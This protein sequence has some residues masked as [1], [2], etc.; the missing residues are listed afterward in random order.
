MPTIS[1]VSDSFKTVPTEYPLREAIGHRTA[2]EYR[3]SWRINVTGA[4]GNVK[5]RSSK[6]SGTK[7]SKRSG[8]LETLDIGLGLR[9][10]SVRKSTKRPQSRR[11]LAS[12][13]KTKHLPYLLSFYCRHGADS[14]H[15]WAGPPPFAKRRS[16]I[17]KSAWPRHFSAA[18]NLARLEED[19]RISKA[20]RCVSDASATGQHQVGPDLPRL[21]RDS[22]CPTP[23][24]IRAL[25]MPG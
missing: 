1:S 14:S 18:A 20:K 15:P 9:T 8:H 13:R 7:F 11:S 4:D 19:D 2:E 23:R 16:L 24:H 12:S 22:E 10:L 3:M 17:A 25:L 6:R 21:V 5:K